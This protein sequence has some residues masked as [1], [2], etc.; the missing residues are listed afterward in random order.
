MTSRPTAVLTHEVVRE[1]RTGLHPENPERLVVVERH[2]R[3]SSLLDDRPRIEHRE[4]TDEEILA[5]HAASHLDRVRDLALL[6]GGDID[7]DTRVSNRSFEVACSASG[8]LIA[9][10]DAVLDGR[11]ERAL[12]LTRP[13]GHHATSDTPMGFCLFNHVAV[14]AAHLRRRGLGRIAIVD[15]DVHHG[16]GT[17]DIF[18]RDSDVLYL[19]LHRFPFYPGTGAP[20]E[21]G[22][23]AGEGTTI[24]LALPV[25]VRREECLSLFREALHERVA[26]FEPEFVLV[27]A[28]FDAFDLDPLGGL[29][30]EI[31]DFELLT[32]EVL[33]LADRVCEGRLVSVLEGGY[34]IPS[35]GALVETHL[36]ALDGE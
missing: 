3:A 24:N 14:A 29:G 27:S 33:D 26:P 30:L 21:R 35:L 7:P 2:L 5:V 28:G 17:Q 32:R 11:V 6:G 15:W 12:A 19:S 31:E 9:C 36:R 18:Y 10:A 34:S 22:E 1:H 4:A 13:P 8:G 20:D 16:N 23:G 25:T